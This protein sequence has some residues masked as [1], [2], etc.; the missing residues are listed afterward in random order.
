MINT[1]IIT[2]IQAIILGVIE[3]IT[4]FLPVSSTGHLY[5]ANAFIHLQEPDAFINLFMVVIQLGAIMA[6]V[7]LYFHKLNP[8]APSKTLAARRATWVLWGKVVVAMLPSLIVGPLVND[9]MDAHLTTWPVITTTLIV[10]GVLFIVIENWNSHRRPT[11]TDLTRLPLKMAF[12]IGVLQLLSLV[13]GTS[14]SGATILGAMLLGTSRFVAAEFSFFLAIPTMFGASCL[15]VLK[16]VLHGNQLTTSEAAVL[17]IGVF[18]SFVVA[19]LAI[20]F[21]MRFIQHHDFKIFGW[22][23]IVLGLV[24]LAYFGAQQ[25][26]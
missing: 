2:I 25:L 5:L 24:V 26:L 17:G 12:A 4:E 8:F 3:G 13:P 1:T 16:F 10:Y 6:L 22:Y 18:V 23:R 15:K 20:K 19:Y 11:A 14:R 7:V 21:L 9:F